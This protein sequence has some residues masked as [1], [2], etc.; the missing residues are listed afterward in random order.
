[1]PPPTHIVTIPYR[2]LRRCS[3]LM[4]VAVSFAPVQP[5]GWPSAIAPPLTLTFVRIEVERLHAGERLRGKRLVQLDQID[6]IERQAGLFQH[7]ADRRHRPD[8][9]QFRRHAG[10]RIAD[11]A[12]ERREA[13]FL[14]QFRGCDDRRR[15]AVARLRRVARGDGAADVER[16][17]QL[18]QRF[19]RG[20]SARTL[21]R[22]ESDFL[23][24][25]LAAVLLDHTNG[26]RND[27]VLEVTFLDR[28]N[29]ALVAAKRERVLFGARDDRFARVVLGDQPGAEIDIRVR[30]DELRIRRDLVAAHRHH[31]HRLGAAGHGG[32]ALSKHDAL[33]AVRDRLQPRRAEPVDRDRGRFDGNAGAQA[34]DPRHVHPLLA[35]GHRASDDHIVDR[36]GLELRHPLQRA[37][38]RDR[39]KFV[40]PHHAERALRRLADR[41]PHG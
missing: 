13:A 21:V 9:E 3:S 14:G 1:M 18:R 8:A 25:G 19:E 28:R 41:R 16:R 2:A 23:H 30:R 10:G 38:D 29:R 24:R 12:G 4:I 15:G 35:L 5:S 11:K 6:L 40:G 33:G 37:P 26:Q 36:R 32:A 20:V 7:L 39:A 31:A 22:I 27:L 34:G 17:L